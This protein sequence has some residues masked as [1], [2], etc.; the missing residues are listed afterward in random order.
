M[1]RTSGIPSLRAAVV[2]LAT[3]ALLLVLSAERASAYSKP[4][5]GT[6]RY[7]DLFDYTDGGEFALSR[8]GSKIGKLVL[9]PG[10]RT[11]STCGS[12]EIRLV[13]RPDVKSYRSASG[14]YAVAKNRG[15]LFVPTPVTFKQSGRS[16][17]G[18]LLVLWGETGRVAESGK[19]ELGGCRLSFYAHK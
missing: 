6:W 14:R 7:Q 18:K 9:Q 1:T 4:P 5:G 16:V 12:A 2:A 3:A 17:A 10:E 19:V 8:D 15:G 13:S 11:T